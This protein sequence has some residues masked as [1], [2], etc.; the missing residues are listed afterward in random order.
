M[1]TVQNES[2]KCDV[3]RDHR[4]SQSFGILGNPE[5]FRQI[6]GVPWLLP[7]LGLPLPTPPAF[8]PSS[9]FFWQMTS[10]V[11]SLPRLSC[12]ERSPVVTTSHPCRLVLL[13]LRLS[14]W[15]CSACAVEAAVCELQLTRVP[16]PDTEA[17][18]SPY[19]ASWWFLMSCDAGVCRCLGGIWAFV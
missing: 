19:W 8:C 16:G 13:L 7:C 14:S 10:R 17:R 9:V 5:V 3:C 12:P 6:S 1:F 18:K 2:V 15:E 11:R 4:G